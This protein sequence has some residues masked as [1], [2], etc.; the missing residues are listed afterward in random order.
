MVTRIRLTRPMLRELRLRLL[1]YASPFSV[2]LELVE[3][4]YDNGDVV[5]RLARPDKRERGEII[6][7]AYKVERK[8]RRERSALRQ[9]RRRSARGRCRLRRRRHP[10][11]PASL[12]ASRRVQLRRPVVRQR[13]E[14]SAHGERSYGRDRGRAEG[15]GL[16]GAVAAREY[17]DTDRRPTT[18]CSTS[19]RATAATR[20]SRRSNGS[21]ARS[22][23]RTC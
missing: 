5:V 2:E 13:R 6:L 22:R 9:R 1:E 8:R 18:S 20:H 3:Q 14:A 15:R 10:C 11:L 16:A 4:R 7:G 17:R 21:T 23:C 12:V 19:T